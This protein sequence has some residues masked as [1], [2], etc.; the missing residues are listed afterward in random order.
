MPSVET[1]SD[2]QTQ[3]RCVTVK[4]CV[5]ILTQSS[6][7]FSF[8]KH[9]RVGLRQTRK[10]FSNL[11]FLNR[12]RLPL[13]FEAELFSSRVLE[14]VKIL[15]KVLASLFVIA[16]I[17]TLRVACRQVLFIIDRLFSSLENK[18][19]VLSIRTPFLLTS[20]VAIRLSPYWFFPY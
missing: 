6:R 17:V 9:N 5:L 14:V 15:A 16:I 1:A 11:H 19:L 3:K 4:Q 2:C 8:K 12:Y 13:K 7:T 10:Q 20:V 18:Y